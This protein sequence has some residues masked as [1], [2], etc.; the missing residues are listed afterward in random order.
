MVKKFFTYVLWSII[1][2]SF[3]TS[4]VSAQDSSHVLFINQVRGA[5]CC[6]Q[7]SLGNV[8]KQAEAFITHNIPAY[9]A[10]RYDAL[11]DPQFRQYFQNISKQ[12]PDIIR[13]ALLI[14]ITPQLAQKAG[15]A[16]KGSKE[17][18]HEA[19]HIFTIG[20]SAQDRKKLIDTLFR[21]FY[22]AFG[23]YPPLTSAWMI[24]TDSFNHINETYRVRIH[25]ITREQWGTD[26]YTL[27]GGPPHYPYPPSKQWLFVPDYGRKNTLIVRQTVT[28][29]L[30]NY[31]D[32]TSAFTSQPNDY[33]NDAKTFDYFTKLLNTA[34][35]QKTQKGFALLGLENS[36][37]DIFQDEYMK[38][39]AYLADLKNKREVEFPSHQ[40]LADYWGKQKVTVYRGSDD[41]GSAYWISSPAY[42]VRIHIQ[43]ENVFID[44]VRV[45]DQRMADPYLKYS[46]KKEGFWVVPYLIDGSH[47]YEKIQPKRTLLQKL[48]GPPDLESVYTKV[49]NDIG[50][51][52]SALVLPAIQK[53]KDMRFIPS[54]DGVV[55]QYGS[56][57]K[58]Q[59][60]VFFR[61]QNIDIK[62]VSKRDISYISLNQKIL[63]IHIQNTWNGFSLKWNVRKEV[64]HSLRVECK[65]NTCSMYF[66]ADAA[67]LE[68]ARRAH[69][70]FLFPEPA[71]RVVDPKK[72]IFYAH[73]RYA[74]AGRNPVRLIVAPYDTNGLPA[75]LNKP[76][77][78]SSSK[79]VS[80]ISDTSILVKDEVQ[81]V[82]IQNG[83]PLTAIIT[84]AFPNNTVKKTRIYFAPN[85]KKDM[86]YCFSHPVQAWWYLRAILGD[87]I[88]AKVFNEQQ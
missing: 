53:N 66:S 2:F 86:T 15:V 26:S 23:Y 36:M 45:Y 76:L 41:K 70:P 8:Q 3:S 68:E 40:E 38:Q 11:I 87:K 72:T 44:D 75:I 19:Q 48:L 33:A 14:E 13:P 63:P 79:P 49:A 5:E 35:K 57:D 6:G 39:I 34:L 31:G 77:V 60:S 24:D 71:D 46:A 74:I 51:T 84:V 16:Y 59:T 12:Y 7:G 42:R 81:Y 32:A 9:F 64:S 29:P 55:L 67:L 85:C 88:R 52:T 18:W 50:K 61:E 30:Y 20:Y 62:P 17:I 22:E 56:K 1:I 10:I 80:M 43:E 69:Y 82:D 73:N 25:Q 28:D 83:D 47:W 4:S 54:D 27:Y 78:I 21:I 37:A 58:K 65:N